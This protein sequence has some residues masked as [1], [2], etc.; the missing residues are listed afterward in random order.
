MALQGR[1]HR[2]HAV[3]EVRV[4]RVEALGERRLGVSG[5]A[6]WLDA[7]GHARELGCRVVRQLAGG[8]GE[9]QDTCELR[10]H[11]VGEV[12]ALAAA[13]A[14][15]RRVDEGVEV[16]AVRLDELVEVAGAGAQ[17]VL[18]ALPGVRNALQLTEAL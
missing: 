12:V 3:L 16:P 10:T 7:A 5:G 4:L 14:Q 18:E 13:P 6:Q 1:H 15:Q 11:V 8:C 9:G 17:V 2:V